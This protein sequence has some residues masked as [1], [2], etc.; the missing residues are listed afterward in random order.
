M[1]KA[2]FYGR[3]ASELE[4]RQTKNGTSVLSFALAVNENKDQS[5]FFD[6]VAFNKMAEMI[7]TY[8]RKGS[9][10]VI[11]AR[12]TQ[13]QWTDQEGK[14]RSKVTFVVETVDF[15]ET[16]AESG[17]KDDFVKV[18]EDAALPFK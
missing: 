11:S 6:F 4:I 17:K 2:F 18:S 13:D 9:R 16:K 14:K 7:Y 12:A 15:V 1:N 8:F 5:Y 3:I 10:I